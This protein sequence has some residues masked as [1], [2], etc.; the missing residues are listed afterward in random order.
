VSGARRVVRKGAVS[1]EIFVG[2]EGPTV[3]M[4][5]GF[6]RS[7][8]DYNDMSTRLAKAGFKTIAINPR[9][10]CASE[11]PL[12][13]L[14]LLDYADDVW[15]VADEL[16]L[17]KVNLLGHAFGNRVM[18][19][20]S[21]D[22][23]NRVASITLF[24]AGGEVAPTQEINELLM[25][26]VFDSKLTPEER[27]E[28]AAKALFAP[29]HDPSEMA[30][31]WHPVAAKGESEALGQTDQKAW[32][33]LIVARQWSPNSREPLPKPSSRSWPRSLSKIVILGG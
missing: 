2:G 4:H 22:Q 16:E 26:L 14:T 17:Q 20:A 15:M 33:S 6:G 10:I 11:G 9:G 27:H 5:P 12:E 30:D 13:G 21:T 28:D 23:P 18:R 32:L 25:K 3:L 8:R 24:A 19:T 7:A 29:G 1:I 31:G